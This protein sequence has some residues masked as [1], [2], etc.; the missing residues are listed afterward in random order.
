[1]PL[2]TTTPDSGGG[3]LIGLWSCGL[4]SGCTTGCVHEA[5]MWAISRNDG[6][7]FLAQATLHDYGF[8]NV[9]FSSAVITQEPSRKLADSTLRVTCRKWTL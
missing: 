3:V 1:M 4:L 7:S 8:C 6:Y 2:V 5:T 9:W